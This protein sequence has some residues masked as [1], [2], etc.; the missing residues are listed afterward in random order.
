M[1]KLKTAL[2]ALSEAQLAVIVDFW[3]L[4]LPD[5]AAIGETRRQATLVEFLYP[6]LQTAQYFRNAFEK[7]ESD[8]RDLV[9]FL[10]IHGCELR[11]GEVRKR[12]FADDEEAMARM[13][14]TMEGK[15][16]VFTE[17]GGDGA[18][19]NIIGLPES[20]LRFIELPAH[21]KGY[22][23]N[24]L[25][26]LTSSQLV[27]IAAEIPDLGG[28]KSRKS[29]SPFQL[30]EWLLVPSNLREHIEN[31]TDDERRF[32]DSL[33]ERKGFCLYRDLLEPGSPRRFDHAKTEQLNSLISDSGLV[34]SV[35]EGNNKY[36]NLLMVPRDI[37]QMVTNNFAVD[38]RC[39]SGL[40][41][42]GLGRVDMVP[43]HVTDNSRTLLRDLAIM[44]S[45]MD[46][47]SLK[48]LTGGGI[49]KNDLKRVL[50]LLGG[51]KPLRY[52]MFLAAFLVGRKFLIPVGNVWRV[53]ETLREWLEKPRDCYWEMY[54]WWL[55]SAD[56]QEEGLEGSVLFSEAKLDS[57]VDLL[58][59]R[60]AVLRGIAS[61]PGENWLSFNAFYETLVPLI[62]TQFPSLADSRAKRMFRE[63]LLNVM[64]E[65]LN[66]LGILSIGAYAG[67]PLKIVNGIEEP[68]RKGRSK[69]RQSQATEGD[70]LWFQPT[71]YGTA[72]FADHFLDPR[73]VAEEDLPAIPLSYDAAWLI[74]QPNLEIMAPP[75]LAAVHVFRLAGFCSI[76]NVD[77][78]TTF[79]IT[80][81]SVR[82][83][84]DRGLQGDEILSFLRELS[85]VDVPETVTH[86]IQECSNKHG[87]VYL[88][89]SGG[90]ITADDPV[91]LRQI[92]ATPRFQPFIREVV[93]DHLIVLAPD[94]DMKKLAALMRH[95][96]LMP[97]VETGAVHRSAE[98]R[99]HL[100]L[101]AQELADVMGAV[102][103]VRYVEEEL[104]ADISEGKS[105]ALAQKLRPESSSF[106]RVRQYADMTTRNYEKRFRA[107]LKTTTDEIAEKYKSQLSRMVTRSMSGR[108]PSKYNYR[109]TNPAEDRDDILK[110]IAFARDYELDVK[111]NYVKANEQEVATTVVPKTIEGSRMYAHC[112]DTDSDAMYAIERIM[113][114]TLV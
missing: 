69:W 58:E 48:R 103:F 17:R 59:L 56:W 52:A 92:A 45:F 57:P 26:G 31:L 18:A 84:M 104:D 77:V 112:Q 36:T 99:F 35:A 98:D 62:N 15:G 72:L 53:D 80:R 109:G 90:T 54:T 33:I 88:S 114:A 22:L 81:E 3:G 32:F 107:A 111:L 10:A 9:Y 63:T 94:V 20:Y 7:L 13:L 82:G 97:H 105:A 12:C 21:W 46:A 1:I 89:A 55:G 74:V 60:R 11:G 42:T 83:A 29:V 106:A 113:R 50:P 25:R 76:R 19:E 61:I 85:R 38:D 28:K 64:G 79:E 30:R 51:A 70:D 44:A 41:G 16:F 47:Q 96:G 71:Q 37:Y 73:L 67:D 27:D 66:W 86:L 95:L 100:T 65:S 6:R 49:N 102:R 14:Q 91:M 110:L 5:D 75:D 24:L 43:P 101:T 34:F 78:M 4:K 40:E 2:R 87:E 108:G 93:E 23:G 8:E 39:L 68:Q